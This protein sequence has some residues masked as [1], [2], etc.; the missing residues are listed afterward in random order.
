MIFKFHAKKVLD[1]CAKNIHFLRTEVDLFYVYWQIR[2]RLPIFIISWPFLSNFPGSLRG[3]LSRPLWRHQL[4]RHSCQEGHHHAQG[5]P[6]GSPY[7][8]RT[9]L[10]VLFHFEKHHHITRQHPAAEEWQENPKNRSPLFNVPTN[11]VSHEILFRI[12]LFTL[13]C[14]YIQKSYLE[15][16]CSK[17]VN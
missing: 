13:Y 2:A 10:K 11:N 16:S 5:Y 1:F 14:I 12:V 3:L 7:P 8:W 4:V 15:Q 6:I 17:F 9:C